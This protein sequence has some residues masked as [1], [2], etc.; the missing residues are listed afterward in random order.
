VK[1]PR[2]IGGP[3]RDPS[4]P[5]RKDLKHPAN[6]ALGAIWLAFAVWE[7]IGAFFNFGVLRVVVTLSEYTWAAE[8]YLG[9][10]MQALVIALC[11]L[12]ASHLAFG[13]PR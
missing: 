2:P 9:W 4:D 13:V 5:N 7:I 6:I 8:D 3:L 10:P 1:R 11:A 12:L